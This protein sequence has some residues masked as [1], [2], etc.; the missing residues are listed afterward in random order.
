[1]KLSV[2]V[3]FGLLTF[4]AFIF[5]IIWQTYQ[6]HII[7]AGYTYK[8]EEKAWHKWGLFVK[9]AFCF[10]IGLATLA[11]YYEWS[12]A[13]L[14]GILFGFIIYVSDWVLNKIMDWPPGYRGKDNPFDKIPI[15]IRLLL[16]IAIWVFIIIKYY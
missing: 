13:I 9:I 14:S 2:I 4:A 3:F 1:M 16:I 12:I 6:K 11:I 5:S 7:K 10:I 8:K 15:I